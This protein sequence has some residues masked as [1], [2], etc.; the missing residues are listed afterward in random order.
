M[1]ASYDEELIENDI[2]RKINATATIFDFMDEQNN[3]MLL[4]ANSNSNS[5]AANN[6]NNNISNNS[7]IGDRYDFMTIYDAIDSK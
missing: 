1:S 2:Q 5:N 4:S 3:E 6:S 7:N